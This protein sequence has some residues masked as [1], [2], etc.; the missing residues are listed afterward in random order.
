MK[1][2]YIYENQKGNSYSLQEQLFSDFISQTEYDF[3]L[4]H[5]PY[6]ANYLFANNQSMVKL[7]SSYQDIEDNTF[8]MDLI[9]DEVDFDTNIKLDHF[10]KKQMIYALASSIAEKDEAPLF[11]VID[12]KL[13]DNT[14]RLEYQPE[15]E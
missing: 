3:Y 13:P 15:K 11:L 4:K 14:I 9:E 6:A 8:G 5:K 7:Q 1:E 2:L 10:S 12:N